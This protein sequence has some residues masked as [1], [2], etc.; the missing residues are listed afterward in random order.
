MFR[1]LPLRRLAGAAAPD[2]RRR[3][4][5]PVSPLPRI[6]LGVA[7]VREALAGFTNRD[8]SQSRCLLGFDLRR[9]THEHPSRELYVVCRQQGL[10]CRWADLTAPSV[11][12]LPLLSTRS[13]RPFSSLLGLRAL[14]KALRRRFASPPT[15]SGLHPATCEILVRA[16]C[17]L[18]HSS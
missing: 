12:E 15:T 4:C 13:S 9:S 3:P 8:C 14:G 7:H 2:F 17:Y 1:G 5:R 11:S 16:R 18:Q 6:K 10:Q